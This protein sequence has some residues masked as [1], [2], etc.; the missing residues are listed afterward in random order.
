MVDNPPMPVDAF[1]SVIVG[2]LPIFAF[3]LQGFPR[4]PINFFRVL[5]LFDAHCYSPLSLE[6]D[7]SIGGP[8][9][10]IGPPSN[11]HSPITRIRF[12]CSPLSSC[13]GMP[14]RVMRA[15]RFSRLLRYW[16]Q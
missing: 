11:D 4:N 10:C 8:R 15:S 3:R 5:P 6:H 1:P 13:H 7:R 16:D 9:S 2:I 14:A 12:P